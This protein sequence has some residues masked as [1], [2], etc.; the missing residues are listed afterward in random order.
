M[1]SLILFLP[2]S[3]LELLGSY[4]IGAFGKYQEP[5]WIL[6][7]FVSF[8][9]TGAL[10]SYLSAQGNALSWLSLLV[11]GCITPIAGYLVGI[12][13]F[14]EIFNIRTF[15]ALCLIV[16]SIGILSSGKF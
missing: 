7:T 5:K 16:V 15:V 2:I 4:G 13:F 1:S 6:L 8:G 14:G 9:T 10:M 3:L 11:F 12:Y